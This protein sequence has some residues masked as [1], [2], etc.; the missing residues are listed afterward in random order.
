[1]GGEGTLRA[2]WQPPAILKCRE[3]MLALS[4]FHGI[5]P[6]ILAKRWTLVSNKHRPNVALAT[7][8]QCTLW[9]WANILPMSVF[10]LGT[11]LGAFC[12]GTRNIKSAPMHNV[13][14]P[15]T[16]EYHRTSYSR[17][18]NPSVWTVI[19]NFIVTA[20]ASTNEAVYDVIGG[21]CQSDASTSSVQNSLSDPDIDL[22]DET[23]DNHIERAYDV[24]ISLYPICS[25]SPTL[26]P[27][28]VG[29]QKTSPVLVSNGRREKR[30]EIR[31]LP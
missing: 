27:D 24:K 29:L 10:W 28:Y 12:P 30:P 25:G 4:I 7:N 14:S 2:G 21:T 16:I 1:M 22:W 18:N 5:G 6:T 23:V 11:L 13:R 9:H 31:E 17:H 20:D 3:I 19:E 8:F 26:P 15:W